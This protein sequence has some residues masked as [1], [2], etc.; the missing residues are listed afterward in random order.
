MLRSYAC[1]T[2]FLAPHACRLGAVALA[3]LTNVA[4]GAHSGPSSPLLPLALPVYR[5]QRADSGTPGAAAR[6]S[7]SLTQTVNP[8]LMSSAASWL[9]VLPCSPSL[10]DLTSSS[11]S[12]ICSSTW[13]SRSQPPTISSLL[14]GPMRCKG[15]VGL[16]QAAQAHCSCGH[17][18]K[19]TSC[20]WRFCTWK[21][22][23]TMG[24]PVQ[25]RCR[26]FA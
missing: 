2:L 7:G 1:R 18:R 16:R 4:S 19:A 11:S 3:V 9:H 13:K 26:A 24:W 8:C 5:F 21:A 10:G 14:D 15:C 20:L 23:A 6:S 25:H 12:S 17:T 22:V